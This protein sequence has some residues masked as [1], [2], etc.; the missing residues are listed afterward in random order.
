MFAV[1]T[2]RDWYNLLTASGH[3]ATDRPDLDCSKPNREVPMKPRAAVL[4]LIL[5]LGLFAPPVS[6][7]GQQPAK[8]YRIGWLSTS[9]H[10]TPPK[11]AQPRATL[12]GRH[13]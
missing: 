11:I 7:H 5:A 10:E 3:A 8:V 13:G 1:D 9:G 2:L 12:T 6:S 4:S